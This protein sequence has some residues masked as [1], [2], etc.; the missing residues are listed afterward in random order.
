MNAVNRSL[1]SATSLAVSGAGPDTPF[2]KR[3]TS[4]PQKAKSASG[5][6]FDAAT[7]RI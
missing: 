7:G 5:S 3:S 2:M 6:S 4:S 1:S